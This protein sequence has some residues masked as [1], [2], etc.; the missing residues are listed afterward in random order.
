MIE[1]DKR[2]R[3]WAYWQHKLSEVVQTELFSANQRDW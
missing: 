2:Q 1:T 3:S